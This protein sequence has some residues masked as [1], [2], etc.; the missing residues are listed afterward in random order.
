M[1]TYAIRVSAVLV[2]LSLA[3]GGAATPH[4][5]A[6]T[7][8]PVSARAMPAPAV[9]ADVAPVP[10]FRWPLDG[11]PRLLRRF[12]P[13]PQPWSPGHRSVDLAAAPGAVVRAAGGGVVLFAGRIAGRGVV[14][15]SH[16]GG[17]RTTYEPVEPRVAT[18]QRLSAG[19]PLGVLA[20]GHP[21]CAA[22]CLHWGLRRGEEYLDPLTLLGLGRVRLL[23]AQT[24]SGRTVGSRRARLS[25]SSA[26]L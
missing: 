22:A 23:P 4:P 16:S 6:G 9:R 12:D 25:Y 14:S 10:A 7:L 11:A 5:A 19:H 8:V 18:G 3:T 13:P 20:A 21:G 26:R 17:L 2:L 1:T 15:V 24:S